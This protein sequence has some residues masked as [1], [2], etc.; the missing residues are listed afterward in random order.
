MWGRGS[1]R[2]P[3]PSHLSS[4]LFLPQLCL[5][6]LRG[7]ADAA[8]GRRQQPARLRGGL[9]RLPADEEAGLL[10]EA[11]PRGF[12]GTFCQRENGSPSTPNPAPVSVLPRWV[13]EEAFSFLTLL[14][15]GFFYASWDLWSPPAQGEVPDAEQR[16]RWA[17]C[18]PA[19]CWSPLTSLFLRARGGLSPGCAQGSGRIGAGRRFGAIP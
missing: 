15:W 8:A 14:F 13:Q 11:A 17:P 6:L 1:C 5:R 12:P 7:A 9:P 4:P 18:G 19:C 10:A 2:F 3:S 16:P